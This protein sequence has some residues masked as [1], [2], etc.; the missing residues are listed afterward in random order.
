MQI[1]WRFQTR[2][3][4]NHERQADNHYHSKKVKSL[5]EEIDTLKREIYKLKT[6]NN[7][8]I[9]NLVKIQL[10]EIEEFRSENNVLKQSLQTNRE[11]INVTLVSKDAEIEGFKEDI[12]GLRVQMLRSNNLTIQNRDLIKES[13]NYQ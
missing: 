4:Y 10:Q 7:D 5:T 8:K 6:E 13:K 2:C 11:Y 9:N 12:E 3:Q 1:W